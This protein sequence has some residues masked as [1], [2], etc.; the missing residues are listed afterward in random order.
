MCT[1]FHDYLDW[2]AHAIVHR[3]CFLKIYNRLTPLLSGVDTPSWKS[4]IRFCVRSQ[5][6][7]NTETFREGQWSPNF[8]AHPN[9][10]HVDVSLSLDIMIYQGGWNPRV[11]HIRCHCRM[12]WMVLRVGLYWASESTLRQLYHDTSNTGLIENN[13]VTPGL[14]CIFKWHHCFQWEQYR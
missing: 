12:V 6:W 2:K 5:N 14:Q 13:G 7:Y 8:E 9:F 10:K 1:H 3:M 4:W 11:N